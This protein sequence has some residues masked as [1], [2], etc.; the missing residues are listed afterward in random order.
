MNTSLCQFFSLEEW[1]RY[2]PLAFYYCEVII[3]GI[4]EEIDTN[5]TNT[6]EA[7]ACVEQFPYIISH[8]A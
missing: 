8:L 2:T 5:E 7:N 4:E 6:G 3:D 1:R